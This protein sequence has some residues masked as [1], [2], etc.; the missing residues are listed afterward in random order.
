MLACASCGAPLSQLKALRVEEA[1]PAAVTH[2][3]PQR[4]RATIPVKAAKRH[5]SYAKPRK[6]KPWYR[7]MLEEAFDF[8]EDIFD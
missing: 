8:V 2:Q 1:Q 4:G 3:R 7:D 5:Q 6:R